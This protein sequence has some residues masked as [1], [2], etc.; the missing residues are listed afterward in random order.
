MTRRG[1]LIYLD[2]AATTAV[3]PEVLGAMLPYWTTRYGNA[4][5]VHLLGREA[6]QAVREA[7]QTVAEVLG[8]TPEEVVFTGCG[9]ESD[10]LAVRGV[11]WTAKRAGRGSHIVTSTVEHHAISH[12]VTALVAEHGF[13]AT[14]VPVDGKGQVDPQMVADA[15]RPD[16]ALV[17]IMYA[18]NEVGT[19][20]PLTD[21][22]SICQEKG[23]PFHTDAVQAGGWLPLKVDDLKVDLLSLGA[24][25]FYGPK[26][27]GVLYVRKGTPL[28]ST[29]T[30]GGQEGGLRAG[31]ENVPYIV[32]MAAALERVQSRRE[33]E[34]ARVQTL[35]DRL[36][37]GMLERLP[38]TY[39]TGHATERLSNNASFVVQDLEIEGVLVG[40]DLEGVCASSGSACTSASAEPSPVLT[41]M[42]LQ[43]PD[44]YG[45]LRLSLGEETTD[46]EI[47]R[48]LE[49]LPFIVKMAREA[50]HMPLS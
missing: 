44:V 10:N 29:L 24:H 15:I 46:E 50:E 13:E 20:Q 48:V 23:V 27:V 30:G 14:V 6:G 32:G 16:T 37:E 9:S 36:V 1:A 4:S 40:L 43:P 18:N 35:R 49:I 11:A 31:T 25:K 45:H 2:H 17:S 19:I 38:N 34:N 3:A 47:E 7:R 39:L 12:T 42:G 33:E 5:S 8:C 26:G 22:G 28:S 21:I 41:A